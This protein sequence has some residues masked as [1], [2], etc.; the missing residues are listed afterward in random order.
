MKVV[1]LINIII[2][3]HINNNMP[4]LWDSKVTFV[5]VSQFWGLALCSPF[6]FVFGPFI[7]PGLIVSLGA[8]EK[9]GQKRE[10]I[11]KEKER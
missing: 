1:K 8:R 4:V 2:I 5:S 9:K 3:I 10:G 7:T 6:G 11:Q